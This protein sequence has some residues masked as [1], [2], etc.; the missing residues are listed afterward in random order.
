[1]LTYLIAVVAALVVAFLCGSI[2]VALIVGK[3]MR[4]LDVREHGSG[5]AG[6]TNAIRVLGLG[7]GML[8][9]AGDVLKAALGCVIVSL[10]VMISLTV[11]ETEA[12]QQ[13]ILALGTSAE[14][15]EPDPLISIMASDQ[16]SFLYD[17]PMALAMIATILGHMF[18]PFMGFKGGKGVATALGSIGVVLPLTALSSFGVF[19]L[20]VILTRYVSLG[21]IIAVITVPIFTVIYYGSPTYIVFTILVAIAVVLAHKK[22]IVRL[23]KGEEPKFSLPNRAKG[24]EEGTESGA[25]SGSEGGIESGAG[26]GSVRGAASASEGGIA[27][28]AGENTENAAE[29]AAEKSIE[30]STEKSS[31]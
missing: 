29:N 16:T 14:G 3:S 17:I 18:S 26:N 30:T 20:V 28:A 15:F 10:V 4:G 27:N 31:L 1:M 8:V 2:P 5:N 7:P 13:A 19:F 21:S 22:N 25:E 9:F 11:A 12:T 6:S 23:M 24:S